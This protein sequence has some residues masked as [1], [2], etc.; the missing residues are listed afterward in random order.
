MN[1]YTKENPEHS[2][3]NLANGTSVVSNGILGSWVVQKF[4]GTSV[5]KFASN[6]VDHV[7]LYAP[8]PQSL[9]VCM[10]HKYLG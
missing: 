10:P 7:V 3:Q 9:A 2:D 5:G 6:I 4:G 8:L 1:L